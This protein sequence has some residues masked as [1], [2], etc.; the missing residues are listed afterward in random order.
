MFDLKSLSKLFKIKKSEL[1]NSTS[2]LKQIEQSKLDKM[3]NKN[4]IIEYSNS[5]LETLINFYG[6][7]REWK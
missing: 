7:I 1:I 5:D 6:R 4:E 2:V 3:I